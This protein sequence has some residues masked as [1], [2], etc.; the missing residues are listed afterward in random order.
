MRKIP[1]AS[2]KPLGAVPA[3]LLHPSGVPL[4]QPGEK[5][6]SEGIDLLREAQADMVYFVDP[7][8][9]V[10]EARMRLTHIPMEVS[11][12]NPGDTLSRTVHDN[13][14]RL[15]LEA[16]AAIPK[17]FGASLERRGIKTIYFQRPESEL[18]TKAG[19]KARARIE[20]LLAGK[21][22]KQEVVDPKTLEDIQQIELEE[23]EA[24]DLDARTFEKKLDK[25][26]AIDYTPTG[27]AFADQVRDTRKTA[28]A[29]AAEKKSFLYAAGESLDD[30]RTIFKNLQNGNPTSTLPTIDRV[31]SRVLGGMIQNR[32]LLMLCGTRPREGDYLAAHSLA[33]AV[34][35][36]N[37]GTTMGFNAAQ[38]KSLAYGAILADV[39]L[40]RI[41]PNIL[42]KTG[43]LTP[44]EHAEIRRHPAYGLDL[45]QNV[46]RIPIEVPYIVYQS[47]ERA[48]GT[49]YPCGKKDVVIHPFA[50]IVS[51]ADIYSSVCAERPY[52]GAR[53][54][55]E[56]VEAVV[57]MCGKRELNAKVVRSF[58]ACNAM[59]PVASFV[60][61]S[62]GRV[63]RV[64]ASNPE[65]YMK[66]V[67]A[68]IADAENRFLPAPERVDLLADDG[69]SVKEALGPADMPFPV[70]DAMIGF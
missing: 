55:Y 63:G 30:I 17:N 25:L 3:T 41:P 21:P 65:D 24:D 42:D 69:L 60:R 64:V 34:V 26:G 44:R 36:V 4:F 1:V 11:K 6:T 68:V 35:S 52:R 32:E 22:E 58:L 39:G 38:I 23:A 7:H 57:L 2:L 28:P 47:H 33:M 16:G 43:H 59:F 15:L 53:T 66:P 27:E 48:N 14:G 9:R 37:V 54:P 49:G 56:A 19:R 5:L 45:L 20:M 29:S 51:V 31:A 62:D 70:Q 61:L 12:L 67:V 8:E 13:Q 18:K 40:L 46:R 10:D 50:K